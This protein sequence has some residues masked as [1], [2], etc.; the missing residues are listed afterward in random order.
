MNI[1]A[2]ESNYNFLNLTGKS[3]GVGAV[4]T[5]QPYVGGGVTGGETETTSAR[6][7]DRLPRAQMLAFDENLPAQAG[8]PAG[9]STRTLW[10]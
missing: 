4:G 7:V 1:N 5:Y 10:A 8:Y 6:A 3:R 2:I 9:I